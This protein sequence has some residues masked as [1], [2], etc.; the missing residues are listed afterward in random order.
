MGLQFS[1]QR[2]RAWDAECTSFPDETP[3][4][5]R[6]ANVGTAVATSSISS[7]WLKC[8][9][10]FQST[11]MLEVKFWLTCGVGQRCKLMIISLPPLNQLFMHNPKITNLLFIANIQ[12]TLEALMWLVAPLPKFPSVEISC[13][14]SL[15]PMFA[16]IVSCPSPLGTP[17]KSCVNSILLS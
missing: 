14:P 3:L 13:V 12:Q 11:S 17:L 10:G 9:D 16:Y 2:K 6:K 5:L 4:A 1:L 8:G 15:L 7:A